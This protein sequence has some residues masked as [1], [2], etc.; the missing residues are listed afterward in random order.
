MTNTTQGIHTALH[1]VKTHDEFV[2]G[3]AGSAACLTI[4][5][6][7]RAESFWVRHR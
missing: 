7:K 2:S 5:I 3:V 6:N 4:E 1:G